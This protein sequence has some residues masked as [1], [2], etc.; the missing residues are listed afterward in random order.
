MNIF[1]II[2]C[3]YQLLHFILTK[4]P[5]NYSFLHKAEASKIDCFHWSKFRSGYHCFQ[6]LNALSA[7]VEEVRVQEQAT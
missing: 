4:N 6:Q 2:Y 1:S 3:S 7:L 5:V